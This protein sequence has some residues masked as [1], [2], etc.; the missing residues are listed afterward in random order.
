MSFNDLPIEL[1]HEIAGSDEASY[2]ALIRASPQFAR[3]V[4]PGT[5]LD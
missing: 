3:N 2:N 1:L 4:T 5:R